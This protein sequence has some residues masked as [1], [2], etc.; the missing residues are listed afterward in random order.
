MTDVN[1][2]VSPLRKR[3]IEDMTLRKLN[4]KT[5]SA[6]IRAVA[7]FTRFLGRSPD[8]AEA[9]DL[10]GYQLQMVEQGVSSI[11]LNATI[12]GLK[13]FSDVTLDRPGNRRTDSRIDRSH[14]DLELPV[15]DDLPHIGFEALSTVCLWLFGFN[16]LDAVNRAA[17]AD[18]SV[19]IELNTISELVEVLEH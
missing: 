5:Q 18:S 9:E 4:P 15:R 1:K 11:T 13:F 16:N 7:N 2:P 19:L 6:Y 3:M 10:R 17:P 8:T 14:H 12:T